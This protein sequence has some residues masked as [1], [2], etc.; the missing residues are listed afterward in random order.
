MQATI[1]CLVLLDERG[2]GGVVKGRDVARVAV[3]VVVL[4]TVRKLVLIS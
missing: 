4:E 1:C 3:V 2:E